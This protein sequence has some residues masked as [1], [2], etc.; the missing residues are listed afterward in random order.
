MIRKMKPEDKDIFFSMTEMFYNSDAVLHPVPQIHHI[1]TFNE[2]MRSD[3]YIN[4]YIFE[5]NG[6][7]AGYAITAKSYSHEAGGIVLWIDELFVLSEYRSNG[8]GREFFN[9]LK[10]TLDDSI[11]RLRLEVESENVLAIN[12]YKKLGFTDLEYNQMYIQLSEK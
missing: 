1:D 7:P 5:Y 10:K 4:G 9:L 3:E 2:I 12:F 8:L 11:V 6:K